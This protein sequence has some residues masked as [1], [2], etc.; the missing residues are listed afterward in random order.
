MIETAHGWLGDPDW[1]PA[2]PLIWEAV[3]VI[4]SAALATGLALRVAYGRS[5]ALAVAIELILALLAATVLHLR[6]ERLAEERPRRHVISFP[7]RY[8]DSVHRIVDALGSVA[9]TV[10]RLPDGPTRQRLEQ[11]EL[12]MARVA[13]R[14]LGASAQAHSLG[15][16]WQAAADAGRPDLVAQIEK[17]QADLDRSLGEQ[18]GRFEDLSRSAKAVQANLALTALGPSSGVADAVGS[19]NAL[20]EIEEA[21]AG[22]DARLSGLR[23]P[24][25]PVGQ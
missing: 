14:L 8:L 13:W 21:L 4:E 5:D 19:D 12:E 16:A 17:L 18:A 22:L 23:S 7:V 20:R 11:Q 6:K 3:L 24:F 1:R 9:S 2:Y 10:R 15:V 25:I